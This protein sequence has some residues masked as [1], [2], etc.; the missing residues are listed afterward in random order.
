[1]KKI[2]Q[3]HQ[4]IKK[5]HSH[6]AASKKHTYLLILAIFAIL[7]ALLMAST[8]N[9]ATDQTLG[10]AISKTSLKLSPG[11]YG[12]IDISFF[13]TGES[14]IDLSIEQ[15]TPIEISSSKE[16]LQIYVM[17]KKGDLLVIDP[18]LELQKSAPQEVPPKNTDTTWI[19]I[20]KNGDQYVPAKKVS[21]YIKVTDK[22]TYSKD[23]YDLIFQ[24]KTQTKKN[25]NNG[26]TASIG[27][28]R[29]FQIKVKILNIIPKNP[30]Q[31]NPSS[32][33]SGNSGTTTS[34]TTSQ[35]TEEK[36]SDYLYS[37]DFSGNYINRNY[38]PAEGSQEEG[39][40][41]EDMTSPDSRENTSIRINTS[42]TVADQ[43]NSITGLATADAAGERSPYNYLTVIIILVGTFI[44]YRAIRS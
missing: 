35:D 34:Q 1:M 38:I 29:E 27:Q 12:F 2:H 42:E 36:S 31:Q 30:P 20:G 28:I 10:S 22:P 37:S 9:A 25:Q 4:K 33:N 19:V 7:P 6:T 15:I 41:R 24:V 5:D 39:S 11:Q 18:K 16:D 23:E 40:P 13:N 44:L 8:A 32:G 43:D 3:T 17:Q 26:K 14:D 21:L